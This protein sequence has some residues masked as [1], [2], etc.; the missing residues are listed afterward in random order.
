LQLQRPVDRSKK[1][2]VFARY[3]FS[4]TDLTRV[5][6]PDLVPA[7]DQHIRLSTLAANFTRD[8]RDNPLDEHRGFLGTVELDF[9]AKKLGSSVDFAKLT[10]QAAYY[11]EKFHHIVWANSIRIGLARPFD[12]SFV[13]LSEQFFSGGGNT[14]RGFPLDSAGPQRPVEVCPNG[15]SGCGVLIQVASGGNELF[16]LNS[17]ARIPLGIKKGLSIVPF[18]DGGN[19]FSDI[20]FRDFTGMYSYSN[21]VGLGL[22]YS[23]PVGPIR[24][25]LGRNLDPVTGV[26]ATQYFISIGQAF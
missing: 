18:Y 3:S 21:N 19:V 2:I 13:P 14:L 26:K 8:T 10:A 1:D 20:G 4:K 22:R 24:V 7:Q 15:T 23:T 16:I 5:L 11:K 12:G 25:D 9:N 17:E 6:I